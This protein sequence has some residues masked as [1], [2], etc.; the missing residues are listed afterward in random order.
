M[1]E[2]RDKYTWLL[3]LTV[4]QNEVD[5]L[6]CF[7]TATGELTVDIPL[8]KL[9][10]AVRKLSLL[11]QRPDTEAIIA[12]AGQAL[13]W[14]ALLAVAG[15]PIVAG[16]LSTEVIDDL[17]PLF[18]KESTSL[19]EKTA[20]PNLLHSYICRRLGL[21]GT[22]RKD[23]ADF[24]ARLT[25]VLSREDTTLKETRKT[26]GPLLRDDI[27]RGIELI[28]GVF[29][30][31]EDARKAQVFSLFSRLYSPITLPFLL[32]LLALPNNETFATGIVTGLAPHQ[33]VDVLAALETYIASSRSHSPRTLA[34]I[35]DWLGQYP[36]DGAIAPLQK[37]LAHGAPQVVRAASKGLRYQG[38]E[39]DALVALV[40]DRLVSSNVPNRATAWIVLEDFTWY[41]PDEQ[42]YLWRAFTRNLVA[43]P[44]AGVSGIASL[45]IKY[46]PGERLIERLRGGLLHAED[47]VRAGNLFLLERLRNK[48]P[49][50]IKE[51]LIRQLIP[52]LKDDSYD[53]RRV[54]SH[55]L[56]SL[57]RQ[58]LS[59]AVSDDLL[60]IYEGNS[61]RSELLLTIIG[62]WVVFF[63]HNDFDGRI[64]APLLR[65]IDN[66][67]RSVMLSAW[68]LLRSSPN[69]SVKEELSRLR[70]AGKLKKEKG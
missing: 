59:P 63:Q 9:P 25:Q 18:T 15:Y 4:A 51:P 10:P 45:I 32:R 42:E 1:S 68:R 13:I 24:A 58:P 37:L 16:K 49:H 65:S 64:E 69:P 2:N 6:L 61:Q 19:T 62:C 29:S 14:E 36:E 27:E 44:Q 7:T 56:S 31:W 55:L 33:S 11:K 43:H 48:Q 47:S 30:R 53:V 67:S 57:L 46:F 60:D 12:A 21:E 52:L 3:R 17:K 38:L 41:T 28:E 35:A 8:L 23:T 26:F 70:R 22:G 20:S 54:I 39:R 50:L 5:Y 66:G 34:S 40:E